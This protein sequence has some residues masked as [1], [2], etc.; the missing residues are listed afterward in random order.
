MIKGLL[1]AGVSL[2]LAAGAHAATLTTPPI[3]VGGQAN[4]FDGNTFEC[5]IVN[6]GTKNVDVTIENVLENTIVIGPF[7]MVPGEVRSVV[8]TNSNGGVEFGHCMFD[9]SAK[10]AVQASGCSRDGNLVCQ[11]A[12]PAF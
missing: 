7:V 1:A 11:A 3:P 6:A 9:V 8:N 2:L 10:K 4:F 5:S 12:V